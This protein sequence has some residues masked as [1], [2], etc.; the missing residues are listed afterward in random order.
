LNQTTRT[1]IAGA[2]VK[3]PRLG[4]QGVVVAGG[5]RR[6]TRGRDALIITAAHV[7]HWTATG[8]M[9]L[10]QHYEEEIEIGGQKISAEVYAVEPVADV[11]VLG[12]PD[13][14]Y[15]VEGA[16]GFEATLESI[17][18]VPLCTEEFPPRTPFPVHVLTHTGDWI[19]GAAQQPRAYAPG[20]AVTFS[21]VI[22]GG[23]SGSPVVTDDGRL[24]G[25]ISTGMN[26]SVSRLHL[27]V[28]VWVARRMLRSK[29]KS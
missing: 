1:K 7:V 15:D 19:E 8:D 4:G 25:V 12:Y 5:C 28:P 29:I 10:D 22:K 11:A 9:T 23:T 24:L 17:E 13:D 3:F 16:E 14:Q 18:P 21:Q 26:G 20:L 27:T 2:T 6:A